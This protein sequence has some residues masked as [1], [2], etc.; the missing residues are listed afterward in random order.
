MSLVTSQ[1]LEFK[2]LGMMLACAHVFAF[3]GMKK[4]P[5]APLNLFDIYFFL[6]YFLNMNYKGI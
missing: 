2:V 6:I 4:N 5:R 1:T 3:L